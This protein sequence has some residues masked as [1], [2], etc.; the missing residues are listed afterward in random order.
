MAATVCWVIRSLRCLQ[1]RAAEFECYY[2]E[3]FVAYRRCP[4]LM[5]DLR[6]AIDSVR[7]RREV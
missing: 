3:I 2:Q 7:A 5:D 6:K 1:G 4:A